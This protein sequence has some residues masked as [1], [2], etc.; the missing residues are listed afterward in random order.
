MDLLDKVDPVTGNLIPSGRS[1]SAGENFLLDAE[2]KKIILYAAR[3]ETVWFQLNIGKNK[4]IVSVDCNFERHANLKWNVFQFANVG[5]SKNGKPHLL[6]DPLIPHPPTIM[7]PGP[8]T[9]EHEKV[10]YRSFV[11]EL[12]V[13][14]Q[15]SPGIK[16]G[17]VLVHADDE[18]FALDVELK[19]WNFT[20]PDK[21][22][23]IPEMN[24]Y[25]RVSPYTGYDYY[26][27]AHEHRTCLNRLPYSWSGETGFA[28]V[29]TGAD[30]DWK[31]WDRHVGPLLD[32]S[33]FKGLKRDAE[34]LDVM[35]L[36]FNENWPID[37]YA[38]YTPSYWVEEA[39]S[40]DYRTALGNSFSAFAAHIRDRGWKDTIFEF[41]L[42][43]K[44]Y[45]R[46]KV[47][48]SSA[49]WVFDEPV[50]T[51]DFWALRWY[52]GLWQEAV[53]PF[54]QDVALWFRADVSYSQY[55]RNLLW[56]IMDVEYTGG[57]TP[58]K[59]RMKNDEWRLWE[60]SHYFEYGSA[61][62]LEQ[63]NTQPVRWCLSAWSNGA[64]GV[65]PWQTIGNE[66]SW[67]TADQNALFY[68]NKNGPVPSVRLKA[69]TYGQQ[70]VEYLTLF[71]KTYDLPRDV[72]A[73][74]LKSRL[75]IDDP[76][77]KQSEQDAGTI[78]FDGVTPADIQLLRRQLGE[79]ISAKSPPYQR[80]LEDFMDS[81]PVKRRAPDLGYVHPGPEV[82]SMKPACD[83]F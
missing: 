79:M 12:Y 18:V 11:C 28:P 64:I 29:W 5:S 43:N 40:A 41:Y 71:M 13:P 72:V 45:N 66:R 68:P 53:F 81:I 52:G 34:P 62:K 36:P 10:G 30:F 46:Q 33:A 44:V 57:N 9:K 14:H 6:P 22:S 61:N 32:G 8:L 48:Q 60:R 1:A 65:L 49:P 51:Q 2:K 4:K 47:Q 17:S 21:L 73:D 42:N 27:L 54:R 25:G 15:M 77:V 78:M 20:L 74:W 80:A 55:A 37:I 58:Q 50:N 59:T 24:A 31:Q 3:N 83:Q 35:Y 69:F 23:F 26:I 63:A 7:N 39:L 56:G 67:E 75:Q 82:E 70:L 76:V 19:V 16:T 38:N